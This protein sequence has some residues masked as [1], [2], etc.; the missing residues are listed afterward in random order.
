MKSK[1]YRALV[2]V[3]ISWGTTSSGCSGQ[4]HRD[5]EADGDP[6]GKPAS[7]GGNVG[8]T[9]GEGSATA[10]V[11]QGGTGGGAGR[12]G[13]AGASAAAAGGTAPDPATGGTGGSGNGEGGADEVPV[14]SAGS[15]VG[16][17]AGIGGMEED[18]G[19]TDAG[20][21]ATDA[22]CD[23][24]WP[25]TKGN[26]AAPPTCEDQAE[27]GAP[28]FDSSFNPWLRCATRLGDHQCERLHLT[29]VCENGE[30]VCPPDGMLDSECWCYGSGSDG[31]TC[32]NQGWVLVDAGSAGASG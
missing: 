21:D 9:A 1:L 28:P 16:G 11:D 23:S 18:G 29:S 20:E 8:G 13:S 6:A 4:S 31:W 25:T 3:G 19:I 27:C 22:F 12:Q 2:L 14:G 15:T 17:S 10:R 7:G 24:S 30:W 32:T 26:P 5:A